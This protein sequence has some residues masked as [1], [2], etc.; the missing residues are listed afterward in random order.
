VEVI[1]ARLRLF[2]DDVGTGKTVEA[3]LIL[4]E[5]LACGRARR[6]L[7]VA[8]ADLHDQRRWKRCSTSTTR[9]LPGTSCLH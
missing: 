2:A 3:D 7:I 4:S 8:P 5:R 9:S 1:P 6:V